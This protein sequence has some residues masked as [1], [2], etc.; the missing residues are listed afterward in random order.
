MSSITC[1]INKKERTVE[2]HPAARLLDIL[3]ED[4]GLSAV[5]EGCGE[6]ECGACSVLKDGVLVNSCMVP[7]GTVEGCEIE[8]L[9][10]LRETE[11]GMCIIEAFADTGAVQCG[12]CTP[13]MVMA[14]VA[15]LRKNAHPSLEEIKVG[16]S[17][18]LCRCTG[19]DMII[20][21]VQLAAERGEGIW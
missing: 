6:G 1:Y 9:E 10:G 7:M 18:N 20:K 13:G 2:A 3:R 17:G 8:T 19:Y 16:L 11:E 15:L 14:S 21:G 5:K 4:L 12:F